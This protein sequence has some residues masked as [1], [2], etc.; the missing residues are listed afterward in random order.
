MTKKVLGPRS[1]YTA[2]IGYQAFIHA[3]YTKEYPFVVVSRRSYDEAL[4]DRVIYRTSGA[5]GAY[6]RAVREA[7]DNPQLRAFSSAQEVERYKAVAKLT[8]EEYEHLLRQSAIDEVDARKKAGDFDR[9]T[10]HAWPL[11]LR[12]A[13]WKASQLRKN[14]DYTD[15]RIL[16]TTKVTT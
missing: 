5:R 14:S 8:F 12:S 2:T 6:T 3:G 15:I 7:G 11:S 1:L 16:N 9:Y 13:E 4:R 10:V